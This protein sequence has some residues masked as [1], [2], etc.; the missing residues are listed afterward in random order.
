MMLLFNW[1][2]FLS[3]QLVSIDQWP[4]EFR[5][6]VGTL[7]L[8]HLKVKVQ[9]QKL[10]PTSMNVKPLPPF[11]EEAFTE[12]ESSKVNETIKCLYTPDTVLQILKLYK[13][14]SSIAI[15]NSIKLASA[16]SQFGNCSKLFVDDVLYELDCFIKVTVIVTN[17]TVHT[18]KHWL[19]RCLKYVA[20]NCRP[21][22]GYPSQV[23]GAT[24]ETDCYYYFLLNQI[25]ARAVF[26]QSTIN[27][28]R[29]IGEQCVLVAVPIPFSLDDIT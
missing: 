10:C 13:R 9:C 26:V 25:D 3:M 24:Y 6:S 21:W 22:F 7:L 1:R 27:F 28:G 29:V 2:K 23:W 11:S 19:V 16:T 8:P 5:D 20:H 14:T 17:A 4:D 12:D 18:E 15:G